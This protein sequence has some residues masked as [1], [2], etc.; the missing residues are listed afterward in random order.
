[1]Q[2]D[3]LDIP[4]K[5]RVWVCL[6]L[7]KKQNL[8][9]KVIVDIGSSNGWLEKEIEKSGAKK[10]I[11]IEPDQQSIKLAKRNV[12]NALFIKGEAGNIPVKS[13]F[14]DIV[15][16]FDV[17]EHVPGGSEK[18]VFLEIKRIIKTG[19]ILVLSTPHDH[20]VINLLDLAWYFGHRHYSVNKIK[21]FLDD[22]GFKI[23]NLEVR[24]NIFSS[25]YLIWLYIAKFFF[26]SNPPGINS[27][28]KL[29]DLGYREGKIGTIF[30]VAKVR[31]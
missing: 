21:E 8:K 10:I 5:G 19:G 4:I 30:L 12:K 29:D 11:G 26:G 7:L 23:T 25:F 16:L 14:A 28:V 22:C 3:S 31:K 18:Q 13:N 17:I 9:D 1:M 24:G 2:N 20:W 27:F 6:D 15:I